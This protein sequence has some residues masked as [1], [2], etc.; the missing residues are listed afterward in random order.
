M[1]A[2]TIRSV[3]AVSKLALMNVL[4]TAG[5]LARGCLKRNLPQ[6]LH[7]IARPVTGQALDGLVCTSKR[8]ACLVVVEGC[9]RPP[10]DHPVAGFANIPASRA[11]GGHRF[12]KV[13]SV[14]IPVTRCTCQVA[15]V[16]LPVAVRAGFLV[17]ILARHGGVCALQ[18]QARRLMVA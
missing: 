5:A 3:A 15:K 6:A 18:R 8:I 4:V 14:R 13:S 10:G 17:A 9:Q 12:R 16:E 11:V 7:R 2:G 1:T